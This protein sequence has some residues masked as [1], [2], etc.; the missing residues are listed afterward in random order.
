MTTPARCSK[1]VL[2]QEAQRP[3]NSHQRLL[4]AP[5][6][7]IIDPPLEVPSRAWRAGPTSGHPDAARVQA[8]RSLYVDIGDN[9]GQPIKSA[10]RPLAHANESP[11]DPEAST[12]N[13][14]A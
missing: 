7:L 6:G 5:N 8:P 4:L 14:S 1:P 13:A 12:S 2:A 3:A 9:G 10:I 11:Q